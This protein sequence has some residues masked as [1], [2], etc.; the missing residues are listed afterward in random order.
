MLMK[1]FLGLEMTFV[2]FNN[3]EL[4]SLNSLNESSALTDKTTKFPSI[5]NNNC[6][7]VARCG[8]HS[9]FELKIKVTEYISCMA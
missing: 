4:E 2:S 6:G 9:N 8:D 7:D 5:S 1:T 3:K